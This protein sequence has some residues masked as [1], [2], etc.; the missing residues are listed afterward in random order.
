MFK[1]EQT[2]AEWRQQMLA[3]GIQ[4]PVPLE[5][6]EI[7]LREE[8]ER[9]LKSGLSEQEIFN[10]AIQK[11]G[12]AHMIQNEFKKVEA[13]KEDREWKFVQ[14]LLLAFSSLFP[15]AVGSQ[16]LYFK[17][18]GSADMTPGQKTSC[19][20]ALMT[21]SL[22]AW[23]GRLNC[24]IF[25]VIRAKRI[26]N[27]VTNSCCVLV[28]LWWI[29]MF[30][31]VLPRHDFAMGQLVVTILWGFIT[32]AGIWIGLILGIENAARE[33]VAMTDS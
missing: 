13:T 9:Q 22:L 29:V 31:L 20:A 12:P 4:T 11:I 1:L 21:F 30:N 15:L 27:T 16:V 5:E 6:L 14:I 28:A 2:I 24:G 8:I 10:S 18:G 3:A 17:T 23:G 32:P 19:L 7:H 33:K 25:P 26:R